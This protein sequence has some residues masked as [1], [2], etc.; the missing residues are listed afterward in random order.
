MDND[1]TK[2]GGSGR[3]LEPAKGGRPSKLTPAV[4]DRIIAAIR[5][6]HFR[7]PAARLAGISPPTLYRWLK[8]DDEPYLGFQVAV[9]AAEAELEHETLEVVTGQIPEDP[10]LALTFLSKRFPA[11]WGPRAP[12]TA[13]HAEPPATM[14]APQVNVLVV[15]RDELEGAARQ[16]LEAHRQRLVGPGQSP[17]ERDEAG[18]TRGDD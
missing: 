17:D 5:A 3:A 12:A 8:A 11:R 16:H 6:G 10:R 7:E 1:S 14:Q 9:E 18:Q 2:T 15:D 4:Q 13:T